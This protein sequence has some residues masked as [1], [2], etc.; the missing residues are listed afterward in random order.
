MFGFKSKKEKE[1]ERNEKRDEIFKEAV[2]MFTSLYEGEEYDSRFEEDYDMHMNNFWKEFDTYMNCDSKEKNEILNELL[3]DIPKL[4]NDYEKA[5]MELWK[6]SSNNTVF[7]STSEEENQFIQETEFSER[8][9]KISKDIIKTL[10][11]LADF[12]EIER[13]L[14]DVKKY[15][16]NLFDAQ[17]FLWAIPKNADP[18][19]EAAQIQGKSCADKCFVFLKLY[20]GEDGWNAIK[21]KY[22]MYDNEEDKNAYMEIVDGDK[23]S[24]AKWIDIWTEKYRRISMK[25]HHI[26][27]LPKLMEFFDTITEKFG[28]PTWLRFPSQGFRTSQ[29]S[30]FFIS[31]SQEQSKEELLR[32]RELYISGVITGS[33]RAY[34]DPKYEEEL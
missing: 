26:E 4:K 13:T 25:K 22:P 32:I 2:R 11:A 1:I 27:E 34:K 17:K 19:D 20:I 3:T 29:Y 31:S 8:D 24:T 6:I 30:S 7:F 16:F 15:L 18:N 33:Y 28:N 12:L 9:N 14:L 10:P 23:E 5:L 21:S